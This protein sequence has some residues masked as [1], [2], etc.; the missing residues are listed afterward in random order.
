MEQQPQDKSLY[1]NLFLNYF[2]VLGETKRC[3]TLIKGIS[4]LG[5]KLELKEKTKTEE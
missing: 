3:E 1:E 4:R 2:K 5:G